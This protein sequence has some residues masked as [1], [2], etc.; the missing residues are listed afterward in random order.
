MSTVTQSTGHGF[1][2]QMFR[3]VLIAVVLLTACGAP[4]TATRPA[5]SASPNPSFAPTVPS[6]P[7]SSAASIEDLHGDLPVINTLANARG[8]IQQAGGFVHFPGGAFASDPQAAMVQDAN[9]HLWRTA[10]QPYVFG[11]NDSGRG[12][13]SYDRVV[14]RWLPVAR[15]QISA[16]GLH[17]AYAEPIFPA[18]A[19]PQAGPGPFPTGVHIR[20][21]DLPSGSD[22]IVFSS[23]GVAP[24]YTVV[25]YSQQGIYLTAACVEG[26]G[27]DSLKLWRLDVASGTL[28]KISDRQGFGWLIRDQVAWMASFEAS[29]QATQLVRLDLTNGQVATWLT[30]AAMQ[31]I[32]ID[33]EGSPLVT[34]NDVGSS[35]LLR[36]SAPQQIERLFSG[37]SNGQLTVAVADGSGTWLGGGQSGGEGIYFFTRAAGVRKVSDFPGLPLG[38][39]R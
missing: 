2:K 33:S 38:P 36:V 15:D 24:F 26:C 7:T 28:A 19:S 4:P 9:S 3:I 16:D 12:R 29:G 11:S 1:R 6:S 14:G 22:R 18:S 25:A 34:L 20:V 21:V 35:A 37:P 27:P 8:D 13:I 5:A 23:T 32:G 17:F 30:G 39:P 10:T 31:L